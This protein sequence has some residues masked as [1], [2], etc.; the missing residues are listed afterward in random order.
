M[1]KTPTLPGV[2]KPDFFKRISDPLRGRLSPYYLINDNKIWNS[3]SQLVGIFEFPWLRGD[4]YYPDAPA[5]ME[6]TVLSTMASFRESSSEEK[7][8]FRFFRSVSCGSNFLPE[9]PN[10]S[11]IFSP[12]NPVTMTEKQ[13]G[14]IVDTTAKILLS[15][16]L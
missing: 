8:G 12:L 4:F 13:L 2:Y 16:V 14:I 6:F 10:G 15:A 9:V 7:R 1:A 5:V 11:V 3:R